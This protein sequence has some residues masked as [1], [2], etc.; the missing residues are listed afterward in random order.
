M[1]PR[2]HERDCKN[3]P[4][5]LTNLDGGILTVASTLARSTSNP[6]GV[7]Q[8]PK[9]SIIKD[10]WHCSK[11]SFAILARPKAES[12]PP[13]DP[14]FPGELVSWTGAC[15]PIHGSDFARKSENCRLSENP[16][17]ASDCNSAWGCFR[18]ESEMP[19]RVQKELRQRDS[20]R[21]RNEDKQNGTPVETPESSL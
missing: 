11:Q 18:K 16:S 1:K 12:D 17:S 2:Y 4:A 20:V 21:L 19:E 8:C 3:H 7:I 9:S 15:G 13:R 5:C 6:L 14:C 10:Y